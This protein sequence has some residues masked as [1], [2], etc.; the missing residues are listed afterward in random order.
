MAAMRTND[1]TR[2]TEVR[3][4]KLASAANCHNLAAANTFHDCDHRSTRVRTS[5]CCTAVRMLMITS[6]VSV[7]SGDSS[8]T[9]MNGNMHKNCYQE[10]LLKMMYQSL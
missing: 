4:G 9:Q 5:V 10:W 2:Q 1:S 8:R 3:Q 7:A 6:V